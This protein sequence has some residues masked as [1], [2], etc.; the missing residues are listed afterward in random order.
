MEKTTLWNFLAPA[1]RETFI[2]GT[3]A[4]LMDCNG[5]HG[6]NTEFLEGI[7]QKIDR[8]I[9]LS[10][11]IKI[12]PEESFASDKRFDISVK[13]D[14]S[15][16]LIFEIKCKTMGTK[17]QLERYSKEAKLLI[18]IG[19]DEWNF[20][21]LD[22]NDREIYPLIKF[23]EINEILRKCASFHRSQYAHFLANFAEH[24]LNE[25][26]Y[27]ELL[28][29]YYIDEKEGA[30]F[31][32]LPNF[33]RYS[34]RFYNMLYWTWFGERLKREDEDISKSF[35]LKT[36]SERSGVWFA[37][38][39]KKNIIDSQYAKCFKIIN[40]TIPGKFYYWIHIELINKTGIIAEA[41]SS[42][43][44]GYIQLRIS[45]EDDRDRIY[46]IISDGKLEEY[47]FIVTHKKPS[48]KNFYYSALRRDL[49]IKDFRYS[50]LIK[51]IKLLI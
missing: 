22:D 50:E 41:E 7:L 6:L 31:P 33:H 2:S 1:D 17:K 39:P 29:N 12:I 27:F 45:E 23:S 5:D 24:L 46:K 42:E 32:K 14:E 8:N 25:S 15:R 16:L 4:W 13:E 9:E 3:L 26:N 43:K 49:S 40:L 48:K 11:C 35:V 19:F 28:K 47:N 10:K 38:S 51:I 44:V 37:L 20:P 30:V 18:R 21:D 36:E 34:Q